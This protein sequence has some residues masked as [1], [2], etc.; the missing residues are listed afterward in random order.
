VAVAGGD[1]K[2]FIFG[3]E[4]G[5][6]GPAG[7]PIYIL[8]AVHM[9]DRVLHHVRYCDAAFRYHS[10]ITKEYKDQNWAAKIGP[11][12]LRILMAM[13]DFTDRGEVHSTV[14]WLDKA[15]YRANRGPHLAAGKSN[16]FRHYQ[17]R[18]LLEL[19]RATHIWGSRLDVV[20]DRWGASQE[21]R[22][23]LEDYLQGNYGLRPKIE[24]VTLVDSLYC[25]LIQIVDL[26]TRL[27]RLV[28]AG[29]ASTEQK[30]L[31]TRLFQLHEIKGGLR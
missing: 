29:T 30:D 6:P 27:A 3:D 28:V 25:D 20:L 16:E 4:S 5:D 10:Q 18:R 15:V 7:E 21:A 1:E 19:H 14:T 24:T 22:R 23:N 12:G 17:V 13:A 26:Y 31:A 9:K 8:A 2:E 11:A